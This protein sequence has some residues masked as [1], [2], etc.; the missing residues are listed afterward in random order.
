MSLQLT[1]ACAVSGQGL[2]WGTRQGET[3]QDAELADLL[4]EVSL[5]HLAAKLGGLD[6]EADWAR[7]LSQGEQ[8]RVA[9][10]RLLLHRPVVA[11]LDEVGCPV[12]VRPAAWICCLVNSQRHHSTQ[13]C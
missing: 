4:E 5:P 3:V 7:V 2:Q 9:L 11:F 12:A 10:L 6:A 13:T 8:Q 1:A